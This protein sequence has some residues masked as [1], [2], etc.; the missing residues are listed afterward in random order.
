MEW[1]KRTSQH[2]QSKLFGERLYQLTKN[3]PLKGFE[4]SFKMLQG[5]LYRDRFLWGL[6]AEKLNAADLDFIAR[7]LGAPPPFRQALQDHFPEAT[8]V[9]LGFEHGLR[10][11]YKIYLEFS[12]AVASGSVTSPKA[13]AKTGSKPKEHPH[14]LGYK[15]NPVANTQRSV[16]TYDHLPGLS[17]EALVAAIGVLYGNTQA[18]EH[19]TALEIVRLAAGRGSP[20]A[21]MFLRVTEDNSSR[22]SFD[23]NFYQSALTVKDLSGALKPLIKHLEIDDEVYSA[24]MAEA[25]N[26]MAGH[27]SGGLDREGRPFLTLYHACPGAP[28]SA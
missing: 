22:R 5:E 16:S 8:F 27:V 21:W 24:L 4:R 12:T 20:D 2:F 10:S 3:L 9:H 18:P 1:C 25:A 14:Y 26:D 7:E 6:P 13:I 28:I 11:T 23:L 19:Q 15:W 17:L